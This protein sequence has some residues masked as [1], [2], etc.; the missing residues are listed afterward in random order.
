MDKLDMINCKLDII[1]DMIIEM[2]QETALK[3][4]DRITE[5]AKRKADETQREYNYI[6][7]DKQ[8]IA[9]RFDYDRKRYNS[10]NEEYRL[11]RE[12]QTECK[13]VL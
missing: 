2:R 9:N 10:I 12:S 6:I 4:Y 5:E 7:Q 13:E 11:D 8:Y 3:D 1:F